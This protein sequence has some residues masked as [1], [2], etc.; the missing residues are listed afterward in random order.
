MLE[1]PSPAVRRASADALSRYTGTSYTI[2]LK[3]AVP[4]LVK[5]YGDTN[6]AVRASAATTLKLLDPEAASKAGVK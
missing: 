4:L 1:H 2:V 5:A 6:A 3:S